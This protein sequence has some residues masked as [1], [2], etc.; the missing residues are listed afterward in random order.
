MIQPVGP[1][2]LIQL[3]GSRLMSA[4][5]S[6]LAAIR[7]GQFR[8]LQLRTDTGEDIEIIV[9]RRRVGPM[10]PAPADRALP[11][12]PS[13]LL[14][15]IR[16]PAFVMTPATLLRRHPDVVGRQWTCPRSRLVP[17]RTSATSSAS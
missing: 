17:Q 5:L 2:L 1:E 10:R 15:R 7:I 3:A 14:P 13:R 16:W 8:L 9:L 6:Y 12:M 11:A 4:S